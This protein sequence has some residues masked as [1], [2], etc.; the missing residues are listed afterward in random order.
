MLE[1]GHCVRTYSY[2]HLGYRIAHFS[3]SLLYFYTTMQIP[4][5]NLAFK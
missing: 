3:R 4:V 1:L 2:V 5:L